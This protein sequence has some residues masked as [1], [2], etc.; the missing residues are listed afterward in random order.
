ME[1]V[2]KEGVITVKEGRTIDDEIEITEGMRFDRGFISPYLITD[3]KNQRVELEKP[4]ILLSEKKISALQ[5]ILPSLEIAAQTR[6]P[7]LIIA[8]DIDGEALAAIILNKLRGQ[9]SVAAVKAPGFG[10]NRKSILGDIA[11]LTG[12]TVFTDE[13]DVK[14]EKATPDMFG[15]TGSV[16]ITKDDTII[17]NGEGDKNLIQSRC[18][19]IRALIND[20]TTSD[21]DRTKLQERLAKL[22]GGVAVIKVGGSSEVEV[23]EKKDRYDDALNATRAAVEEGIVPGGGT[24]LLVS[25]MLRIFLLKNKSKRSLGKCA[26]ISTQKASTALEDIA[27]DNF[28]QK[29][30]ISMIRQAIRRPVRTIVENAGE[31]GSVV[32]G[33]LLSDEYA[34]PEKFNWGYDAQTS[35]YRDMIAAGILDPLKVVRTA[36]VDAS[37]VAS[38]LTTSEACVV[39]AE[40]KTPPA[41]MG[42]GGMGGMGGMPGMM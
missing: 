26:D 20:S 18:E 13:L 28:D 42:M 19:Q 12:G 27:V 30:G 25:R 33:R 9:L 3:T 40:E 23:G 37:G 14:L 22:G 32:V 35:Q 4:F 38:L 6:R 31:E 24:A 8:E 5:D 41:G 16:T 36:L 7:L 2:G 34:A 21:Y 10:D 17:L 15:T 29:L 39:D 1:Q 11:I